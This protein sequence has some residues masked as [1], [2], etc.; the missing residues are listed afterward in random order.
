[1]EKRGLRPG[2]RLPVIYRGFLNITLILT[3][4]LID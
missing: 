1:M 2:D 3:L 4:I